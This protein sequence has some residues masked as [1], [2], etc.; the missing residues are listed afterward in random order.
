MTVYG[1]GGADDITTYKGYTM[2]SDPS[3]FGVVADGVYTLDRINSNAKKGPYGSEW[4]LNNRGK[5]AAKDGLNPAHPE[6]DPG[7]LDGV[8][9][10]RP[11]SNGWAGTFKRDG[12][13][14]GVSEGCLLID[15]N[16]WDKFNKQLNG[17]D[18]LPLILKR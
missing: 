10:H 2:S 12:K 5:V 15:P 17:I 7:C 4:T 6:R 1:S 16:K 14:Y 8:F 11:N 13:T 9:V 18:E 3:K